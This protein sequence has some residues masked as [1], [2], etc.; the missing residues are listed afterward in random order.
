MES[1]DVRNAGAAPIINHICKELKSRETINS[2]VKWDEKQCLLSP[3]THVEAMIINVLCRRNPLY[4]VEDFFKEQDTEL[5]FGKG[6]TANNFNDDVLPYTLDKISAA[7]PKKVFST[8]A[9]RALV[10]ENLSKEVLR[11]DTT[12]RL[13]YGIYEHPEGL[14][15][16]YGYNKERRRDLK[17]FKIGLAVTNDGFPILGEVLDGNPSDKTWNKKLLENIPEYFNMDDLKENIL[18]AN[19]AFVTKETLELAKDK[20]IFISRLPNTFS[21]A[22]ELTQEAYDKGDWLHL[23]QLASRKEAAAYKIQEF[24]KE[25]CGHQYRFIVVHSDHLDKR[26]LNSL[27]KSLEKQRIEL[28]KEA[29]KLMRIEFA[30][31]P[32]AQSAFNSFL[33][34]HHN[35]FYPIT[36]S[37]EQSLEPVKRKK[38]WSSSQKGN[39]S[40]Y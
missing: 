10:E 3:G 35:S 15:I 33:K 1:V 6:V 24:T 40:I 39:P 21:L 11:V 16:T 13:T 5:I 19:S 25:F 7:N 22:S 9:L 12:A 14:Q 29:A 18:V 23:G 38:G 4:Q 31:E 8:V 17:Q 36:F 32:D 26:R 34:T 30:C 28:E 20:C 27:N 37:I 2:I